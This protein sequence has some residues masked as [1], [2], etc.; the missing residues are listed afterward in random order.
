LYDVVVVDTPAAF[1]DQA[2]AA[3]D[4][5]DD[6]LLVATLDVPAIK[7]LKL[8]LEMLQLLGYPR[9]RWHVVLNR[10]DAKVG[11]SVDDVQKMLNLPIAAQIP[12]SRAVP[13][14]INRG[15]PLVYDAPGHGVSEAIRR[16]AKHLEPTPEPSSPGRRARK[17]GHL[18]FRR[19]RTV[20][21]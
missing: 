20:S 7:N 18:P 10:A 13:S 4:A 16:L 1:S 5:T 6:F 8:T 9:D 17:S 2:L 11:L 15:V 3:F 19:E 21:A 14:S 12:S